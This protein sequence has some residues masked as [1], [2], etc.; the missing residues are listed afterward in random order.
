VDRRG[1]GH[2]ASAHIERLTAHRLFRHLECPEL[3]NT[4]KIPSRNRR[5]R[6]HLFD[7]KFA[8]QLSLLCGLAFR[9]AIAD[10]LIE[11]VRGE[12]RQHFGE[13]LSSRGEID[14]REVLRVLIEKRFR[15]LQGIEESIL[16]DSHD[17]LWDWSWT[18]EIKTAIACVHRDSRGVI[19]NSLERRQRVAGGLLAPTGG[20]RALR[21]S[22]VNM[23]GEA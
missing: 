5:D 11:C 20:G 21:D 23:V 1:V 13:S 14:T 18:L 15:A 19:E 9:A 6:L 7:A 4:S 22:V 2:A 10:V 16:C 12:A 17:P 8:T 3:R